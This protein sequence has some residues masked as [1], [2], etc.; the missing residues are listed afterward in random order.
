MVFSDNYIEGAIPE[1]LLVN[2]PLLEELIV[3]NNEFSGPLPSGLFSLTSLIRLRLNFNRFSGAIP[4]KI[5]KLSN[6]GEIC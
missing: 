6:L 2:L 1:S 5:K 3:D 4:S